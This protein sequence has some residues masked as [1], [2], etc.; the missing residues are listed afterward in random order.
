M[1]TQKNKSS[2][3]TTVSQ[4]HTKN[5][6]L[7]SKTRNAVLYSTCRSRRLYCNHT[8][9]SLSPLRCPGWSLRAGPQTRG[10]PHTERAPGQHTHTHNF[11]F[12]GNM[13][14][15][16]NS[17]DSK[18]QRLYP[19]GGDKAPSLKRK[20]QTDF[21]HNNELAQK[22]KKNKQLLIILCATW[23]SS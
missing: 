13:F 6:L 10:G 23:A 2:G 5:K 4:H 12:T 22:K 14:A 19:S 15:N 16:T 7:H 18:Q 8:A 17:G 21:C 20:K 1:K 3:L 9:D 11:K